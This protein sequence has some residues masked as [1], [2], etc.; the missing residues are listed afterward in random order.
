MRQ[1]KLIHT[2]QS[3]A[4]AKNRKKKGVFL[5]EGFKTIKEVSKE[6]WPIKEIM[7]TKKSQEKIDFPIEKEKITTLPPHAIAAM[8]HFKN[9]PGILAIIEMPPKKDFSQEGK[10]FI[11]LDRIN[12]PSN[13]GALMRIVDWYGWDGII[14]SPESVD[15]FNPKVIQ[16]SMGSF[17]R[18]P[19]FSMP[20]KDLFRE[21][22]LPII[23]ADLKGTSIDEFSFPKSGILLLGSESEGIR[24]DFSPFFNARITI[25]RRGK[26][27]SLNVSVAGGII[28]HAWG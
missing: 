6:K 14:C 28:L 4:F 19:T 22:K 15:S 25:P 16:A 21:T 2:I 27:D 9:S 10:R 26:V 3:L 20:L 8:S 7:A 17:L 11:A 1:S 13:L 5:V 18:V 23:A 12:N 24:N